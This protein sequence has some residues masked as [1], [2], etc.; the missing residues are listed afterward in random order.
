[1]FAVAWLDRSKMR[2]KA[3]DGLSIFRML[4]RVCTEITQ[5]DP[6]NAETFD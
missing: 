5:F 3:S 6:F 4:L 2:I 1:M